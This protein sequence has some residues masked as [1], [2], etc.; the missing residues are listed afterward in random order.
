MLVITGASGQLGRLVINELLKTQPA[1]KLV[2]LVRDPAKA[3]DLSNQGV[4]V[5]KADYTDPASLNAALK[6]ATRVLLISSSEVGQRAVQ[7]QNVIDAAKAAGVELLAYTSI[8]RAD[9]SPL[10]LAAEHRQTEAALQAS[11]LPHALLRNGW[12]TENYTGSARSSI[13]HGGV[14]GCAGDGRIAAA[15]RA[16]YAAAAAKVLTGANQAGKVY[17]LAGDTS[18][19]LTELAAEYARQ[20]GKA[21][22]YKNLS[23]AEFTALLVNVGLPE[24]FAAILADSEAGAA[25][26]ALFDDGKQLSQLIGRPTTP[27]AEAV[28]AAL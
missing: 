3:Q 6:G 16:D 15:T 18:F 28:K 4:V 13:E 24:G 19:T 27:L 1:E 11:G 12:Y 21:L 14:A 22:G 20:A 10:A 5:R 25:K 17:E 23:E 26:G 7:H 8:L 2:A 9:T